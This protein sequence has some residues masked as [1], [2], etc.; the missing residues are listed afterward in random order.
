MSK[1]SILIPARNE[2]FLAQTITNILENAQGDTEVI[3]VLDG[4]WADP[5]VP[6]DPRVTL[7]Y[8]PQSIGQ[9]AATNEAANISK[10]EFV[11]KVD[12]HCAFAPGFDV[13]LMKECGDDWI[14]VPRMFNLHGFDWGCDHCGHRWYMGPDPTECEK[15]GSTEGFEQVMVWEPRRNRKTDFAR[16][17]SDL[18]FKYWGSYG[19]RPEAQGDVCDLMCFVGAAWFLRRSWYWEIGGC[20][21][22]HGSWGQQGVEM[23]CKGWLSGGRVV[24]NKRTWFSHLFRT[25]P[26]FSFPYPMRGRDVKKARKHSRWLWQGGNWGRAVR[27]LSW[28]LDKFWPVPGWTEEELAALK[29]G[30][31]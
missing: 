16:F 7:V 31:K 14:V 23:S 28:I 4:E 22:G 19:S 18:R 11:M 26:G 30:E 21:E 6:D 9:R 8:H 1:L 12:A 13:E 10:A 25:R 17:N 24:V 27:K 15:C 5:R 20:D 3:A 29:E 2:Q